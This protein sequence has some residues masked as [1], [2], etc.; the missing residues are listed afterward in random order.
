MGEVHGGVLLTL[1]LVLV[2]INGVARELP[3]K[4]QGA[5]HSDD[6][7]L[8]CTEE[9]PTAANYR[10]QQTQNIFKGWKEQ[11]LVKSISGIPFILIEAFQLKNRRPVPAYRRADYAYWI[12]RCLYRV[13]FRKAMDMETANWENTSQNQGATCLHEEA[14]HLGCKHHSY[15]NSVHVLC[16]TSI[17]IQRESM[18][19][20]R[21][22]QLRSDQTSAKTGNPHRGHEVNT[23]TE[24]GNRHRGRFQDRWNWKL[25]QAVKF[26]RFQDHLTK[27]TL[28]HHRKRGSFIRRSRILQRR[29][30]DIRVY[31]PKH[32]LR[33]LAVPAW[34]EGSLPPTPPS[35]PHLLYHPWC[36]SE[37]P[38]KWRSKVPRPKHFQPHTRKSSVPIMSATPA[39]LRMQFEIKGQKSASSAQETEKTYS[40]LPSASVA[41]TAQLKKKPCKKQQP[42]ARSALMFPVV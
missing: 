7:V 11:R 28:S 5:I 39:L 1:S 17:R 38:P 20:C 21:K 34:S 31:D 35:L 37:R 41:L 42:T 29:H 26:K 30:G 32:V 13:D 3:W 22:V 2:F 16:Q 19:H 14:R 33:C 15:Q 18:R 8:W 23:D 12:Q 4:V 40:A 25:T 36:W 27:Q 9:H 10:L 6:L 24:V